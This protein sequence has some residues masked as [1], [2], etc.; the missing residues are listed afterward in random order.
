MGLIKN[1]YRFNISFLETT[2]EIQTLNMWIRETNLS[3]R[4][5]NA[6]TLAG[7]L[8]VEQCLSLRSDELFKIPNLGKKTVNEISV[9]LQNFKESNCLNGDVIP[10][11]FSGEFDYLASVLAIPLTDISLSE[12]AKNVAKK[13]GMKLLRD[14][15]SVSPQN[16][17]EQKNSGKKTL[18][19]VM[20]LLQK[21]NL[22]PG[23]KID[24]AL[25]KEI[26]RRTKIFKDADSALKR[27]RK[28]YPEKARILDEIKIKVLSEG[29]V[30]FYINC[31]ALYKEGG[32]L[33]YVGEK[34]GLTRERVRQILVKGTKNKLFNY[35][36]RHY[37]YISK[38][39]LT[40]DIIKYRSLGKVASKN[41]VT[42]SYLKRM[43]LSY[44]ITRNK[45][46]EL[47]SIGRKE[48]IKKE[49]LKIKDELGHDP[50][51]TELQSNPKWRALEVRMRRSWQSINDFRAELDIPIPHRSFAETVRPWLENRMKIAL[52]KRM[53]DLDEIR[54]ILSESGP[55]Q[56]SE[57]AARLKVN[58]GRAFKLTQL[59][60]A[61]GEVIKEGVG[62]STHY[63]ITNDREKE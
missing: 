18:S 9:Y 45:M 2:A 20:H 43:L 22:P 35:L 13:M 57:I 4:A 37:I 33:E 3:F 59:L 60:I 58:Y 28:K 5:V 51:S 10:E 62:S 11:I 42:M 17:F 1:E 24:L 23:M 19:E 49:Y 44:K 63:R 27:F 56:T 21:L 46:D 50:T 54:E 41:K 25:K 26:K 40:N 47:I 6:L 52:I 48:D 30:A 8:T 31:F 61:T 12:R 36:G 29:R 55:L 34:T 53:Q 7:F 39:K 14:L 32:T 38:E 15:V 16:F